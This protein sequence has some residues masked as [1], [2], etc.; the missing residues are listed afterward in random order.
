M[1]WRAIKEVEAPEIIAMLEKQ[2]IEVNEYLN[3]LESIRAIL[4]TWKPSSFEVVRSPN[5][6]ATSICENTKT[7]I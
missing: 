4:N 7:I 6:T 1:K 3:D 2:R 5:L